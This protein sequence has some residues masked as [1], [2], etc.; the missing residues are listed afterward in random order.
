MPS[1][2]PDRSRWIAAI[3]Q[4]QPFDYYVHT[5][6]I[7]SKHFEPSDLMIRGKGKTVIKGK[8]PSIFQVQDPES[9]IYQGIELECGKN[10]IENNNDENDWSL[11]FF[12]FADTDEQQTESDLSNDQQ[13][14]AQL[15]LE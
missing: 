3:E 15:N 10:G 2:Q 6:F 14:E 13:P 4:H 11:G 1:I 9:N 7:C 8:V 12:D 5:Y